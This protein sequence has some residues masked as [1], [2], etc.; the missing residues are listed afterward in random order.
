VTWLHGLPQ[1]PE[2]PRKVFGG[3]V[4]LLA[5]MVCHHGRVAEHDE[6]EELRQYEE[7]R[8]AAIRRRN[9]VSGVIVTWVVGAALGLLAYD[10]ATAALGARRDDRPWAYPAVVTAVC[11]AT[12]IA[13]AAWRVRRGRR[14]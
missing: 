11:C 3:F 12:L 5:I 13:L 4:S 14:R 6:A 10:S 1:T 7:E 9:Q 2:T 8:Q